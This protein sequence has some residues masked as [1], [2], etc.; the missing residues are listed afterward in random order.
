MDV[1]GYTEREVSH[2]LDISVPSVKMALFRGRQR[3][4]ELAHEPDNAPQPSLSEADRLRLTAYVQ[5]FNA[6]EFDSLREMLAEDVRA[7]LVNRSQLSGRSELYSRYF[8][9][10]G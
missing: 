5:R 8:Y 3:L 6:R 9:H 7:E 1:F 4:C 10:Y 2:I